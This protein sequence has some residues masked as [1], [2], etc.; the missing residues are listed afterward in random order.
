M[1]RVIVL[2]SGVVGATIAYELSLVAELEVVVLDPHPPG[3]G[4][5][6]AALGVLMAV[7]SQKLKGKRLNLRLTSLQRYETLIPELEAQIQTPIPYNRAGILKLSHT[8]ADLAAWPTLIATRSQQGWPLTHFNAAQLQATYPQIKTDPFQDGLFSPCDR[9]VHPLVLTQALVRAAQQNGVE[10]RQGEAAIAILGKL[11]ETAPAHAT[12]PLHRCTGVVTEQTTISADWVVIAAGIQSSPLLRSLTTPP[13]PSSPPLE[14]QPVLGQAL[15][16]RLPQA[17]SPTPEPVIT[18][19]D[20]HV[21]PLGNREYW[22]GA[23]VEF[24]EGLNPPLPDPAGLPKI[25]EQATAFYPALKDG[26]ILETWMGLRPR[27]VGRPAPV[28]EPLAGY[29]NLLLATGHYRNGVLLAPVTAEMIKT[30]I[31]EQ[32]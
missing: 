21:V 27:P 1:T 25:L 30:V 31:L 12:A 14:I 6:R 16:I 32:H 3:S 10:F 20:V 17:V 18:A 13:S 8:P 29:A 26:E 4:A 23:T 11:G 28:V 22:L 24:G 19:E 5:T 2:G 7:I 15:R 9:Q